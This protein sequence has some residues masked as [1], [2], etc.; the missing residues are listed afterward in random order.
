MPLTLRTGQNEIVVDEQRTKE[1]PER[2]FE[3]SECPFVDNN[4][5]KGL[6][7]KALVATCSPT[8]EPG[9]LQ[10]AAAH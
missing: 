7:A 5:C 3:A 6:S 1:P 9:N 8:L 2:L 4:L 10:E